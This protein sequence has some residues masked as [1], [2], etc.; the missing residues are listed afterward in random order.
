MM[1]GGSQVAVQKDQDT[2]QEWQLVNSRKSAQRP[3]HISS[4]PE[5]RMTNSFESLPV[6][7]DHLYVGEVMIYQQSSPGTPEGD[8]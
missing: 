1:D 7:P 5:V 3:S 2:N 4:Q 6:L 8:G